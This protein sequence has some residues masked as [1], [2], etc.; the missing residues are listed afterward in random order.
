MRVPAG[1]AGVA[2]IALVLLTT[3]GCLVTRQESVTEQGNA[4]VA[5]KMSGIQEGVTTVEDLIRAFGSPEQRM[6]FDDGREVLTYV[7]ERTVSSEWGIIFVLRSS[8]HKRKLTRYS[9]E[10]KEGLLTH[11]WQEDVY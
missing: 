7:H 8:S 11:S 9:F 10:F 5:G 1:R 3:A 2:V 4:V 6:K